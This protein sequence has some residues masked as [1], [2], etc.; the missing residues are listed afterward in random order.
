MS[1][2]ECVIGEGPTIALGIALMAL[3]G[4]AGYIGVRF[5]YELITRE[6][7]RRSQ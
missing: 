5:I 2:I 6:S 3:I 7:P 1:C 4:L